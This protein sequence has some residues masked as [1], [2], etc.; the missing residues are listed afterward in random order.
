MIFQ[1]DDFL[2]AQLLLSSLQNFRSPAGPKA[3]AV[4]VIRNKVTTRY[5]VSYLRR[6]RNSDSQSLA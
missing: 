4:I 5:Y 1:Y 2:K 6:F 3:G